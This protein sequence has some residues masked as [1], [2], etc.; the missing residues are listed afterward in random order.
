MDRPLTDFKLKGKGI[1]FDGTIDK[2]PSVN[3]LVMITGENAGLLLED[4]QF[5]SFARSAVLIMNTTGKPDHPIQL[6]RLLT[7][8]QAD[9]KPRGA[10]YFDAN[11]SVVALAKND[12]IEIADLKTVGIE[13]ANAIQFK[14]EKVL[15]ANVRW[16]GR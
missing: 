7:I 3:E 15:G 11:P 16:P 1:I 9:E 5:K 8:T 6:H 4:L 10:I 13:P 14:D 2:K 12:H